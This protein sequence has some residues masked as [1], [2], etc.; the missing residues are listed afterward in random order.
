MCVCVVA[1][2]DVLQ[3]GALDVFLDFICYP[4]G[5]LPEQLLQQVRGWEQPAGGCGAQP[6]L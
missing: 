2:P 3:P 4:G 5:P 1:D 6:T